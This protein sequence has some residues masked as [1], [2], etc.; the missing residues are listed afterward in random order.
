MIDIPKLFMIILGE[1][2]EHFLRS[3]GWEV[4]WKIRLQ[5]LSMKQPLVKKRVSFT[6]LAP[7]PLKPSALS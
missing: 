2:D 4:W 5:G 6:P 1:V 3:L 7:L